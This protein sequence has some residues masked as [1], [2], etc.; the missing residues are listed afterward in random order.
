MPLHDN[1]IMDI[2]YRTTATYLTVRPD[3]ILLNRLPHRTIFATILA[4]GPARTLY[5]ARKPHCRSL[6]GVRSLEG[7]TCSDCFDIK[8]CTSQCR[9]HLLVEQRPHCLLL[10]YTSAKNFLS[11]L[12]KLSNECVALR[13]VTTRISVVDRGSWGE[14][15]FARD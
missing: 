8:H 7:K 3:G 10:A 13:S 14:L 6:D 15:R 2:L 11:Y 4:H 1:P 5:R 12:S 9:I